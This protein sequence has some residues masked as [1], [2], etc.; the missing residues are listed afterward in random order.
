MPHSGYGAGNSGA[1]PKASQITGHICEVLPFRPHLENLSAK[2][3]REIL[4]KRDG[5]QAEDS[6]PWVEIHYTLPLPKAHAIGVI[7][8]LPEEKVLRGE[9][10]RVHTWLPFRNFVPR[11]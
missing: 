4:W 8:S 3:Q 11:R 7:D 9:V 5:Y 6:G 10:R 2:E 1:A